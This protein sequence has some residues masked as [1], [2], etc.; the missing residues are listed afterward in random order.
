MRALTR[1]VPAW[2]IA[3]GAGLWVALAL[4][5][6]TN[7]ACAAAL[8][9]L[10]TSVGLLAALAALLVI[11]S[12]P[13]H[14]PATALSTGGGLVVVAVAVAWLWRVRA[15]QRF[16]ASAFSP[17]RSPAA[18]ER[19]GSDGR[20]ARSNGRP[21]EGVSFELLSA[22]DQASLLTEMR[23]R[24]VQLQAAWDSGDMQALASMTTPDMLDQLCFDLPGCS[25]GRESNCTDVVTLDA[26]LLGYE[27]MTS[28]FLVS[29]EFS[30]LIR[31]SADLGAAP[32]RE[33]W[34][35]ARSKDH[36]A[37]WKLARQQALL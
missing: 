19:S 10:A 31:E 36:D 18:K 37:S 8:G 28:A 11:K 27:E 14:L 1:F 34:M 7:E 16:S 26:Q 35:L 15:T 20:L 17:E 24:F 13:A 33:V 3:P 5:L 30:G 4:T 12:W 29:V 32:F 21:V 23:T 25:S 22:I 9:S 2:R 6:S